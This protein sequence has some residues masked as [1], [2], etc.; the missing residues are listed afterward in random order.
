MRYWWVNH[1]QTMRQE[2]NGCY[3]WS[4]QREARGV[5]SQFYDNMRIAGPGDPVLSFSGGLIRHAGIV[6][7]FAS[8]APKPDDFDSI[9]PHWGEEG[10]LLPVAWQTLV[11][12]I[13]P[14]ERISEFGALLPQ[15]YSPI[16]PV[17]GN[18]NQKAYLAEINQQVFEL[19]TGLSNFGGLPTPEGVQTESVAL[20]RVEDALQLQVG[21]DAALDSTTKQQIIM[22]RHGQGLFRERVFGL[23]R[24]C[25]LTNIENPRLLVASHI[26]PWRVCSTAA[27]RL[28]G[29]NGLL[30]TPHVD[31]LFDRGLISFGE[32]GNVLISPRL[33]RRD[34]E[35]LGLIEACA[36]GCAPFAG[37]QAAYLAFHR[38][39]VFLP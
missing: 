16:H 21:Q 19:L 37:R 17:S 29:A 39:K 27:E 11:T 25:R 18:G 32:Q 23:E 35:R 31:R 34:L 3:L 7:D 20:T 5:R 24:S 30:L 33:D 2:V 13:R 15:K 9:G 10:W 12:P 14:K 6:Q 22:A 8:P 4:P 36:R 38:D 28:D 1:K 26:K